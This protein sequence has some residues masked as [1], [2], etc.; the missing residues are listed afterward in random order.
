MSRITGKI[1][2]IARNLGA[3]ASVGG[4]W[5]EAKLFEDKYQGCQLP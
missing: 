1:S 2:R 3:N 4:C 5:G